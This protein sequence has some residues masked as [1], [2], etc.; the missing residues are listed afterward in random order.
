MYLSRLNLWNFRKYGFNALSEQPSLSVDFNSG[1]NL[2]VGENDSGKTSI[3]DAI[4]YVLGTQSYD[5][6]RLEEND[7]YISNQGS[8]SSELKIECIFKDLSE[9]ECG[10]FLEWINFDKGKTAELRVKLVAKLQDNKVFIKKTAG[11]DGIDINFNAN[12]LLRITYLKPL[13]DAENELSPGYKSRFA[14]ILKSHPL[15]VKDKTEDVHPLEAYIKD[16]NYNIEEYFKNEYVGEDEE[17]HQAAGTLIKTLNSTLKEFIGLNENNYIANVS[18]ANSELAKILSKLM[19]SVD[20]NKVGLGTLNQLYIAMELLLLDVKKFKQ[21]FGM[22]LIEEIEAHLHPQAQLRLIKYL[23]NVG[24][25][26]ILTTH[27]ITLASIVD[28]KNLILCRKGKTFALGK[29]YTNLSEGDYEFLQRFLDATKANLF[30]AKGVIMV[31]GDAEN[32]LIPTLAELIDRPLHRYGVSVVNV[33]NTA[34]LRYSNIFIRNDKINT[35]EIPVSII[36]DTDVRPKEYYLDEENSGNS[37]YYKLYMIKNIEKLNGKLYLNEDD[38]IKVIK[39]ELNIE[40]FKPAEKEIYVEEKNDYNLYLDVVKNSKQAKYNFMD[41]C[42][43]TN[44]WTLE[45]DLALSSLKTV[46]R[47][48]IL[49]AIDI[50]KDEESINNINTDDY[51]KAAKEEIDGMKSSGKNDFEV[52]YEIF[53]PLL[54]NKASKAV[55]AQYLSKILKPL[56]KPKNIKIIKKDKYLKYLLDS[57]YHVTS[58]SNIEEETQENV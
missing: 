31:E 49:I 10:K 41:I 28:L 42:V 43:F 24:Q 34:F 44:T 48:A 25:Q 1:L 51:L 11:L 14:Q 55:T 20:E 12:D 50:K 8:R 54:K 7:F 26:V 46:L 21:E 9:T 2:I 32:I 29:E 58:P 16:A 18:I 36:T 27:S 56:G 13:R 23:Q 57:I 35:L 45:Y 47:A 17:K 39:E 40:R 37:N 53:K 33:G 5:G 38:A 4:K 6:V 22:A 3:V 19:L 30:F 15:F 52:A